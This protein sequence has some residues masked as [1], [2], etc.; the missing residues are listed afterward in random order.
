MFIMGFDN[1]DIFEDGRVFSHKKQVYLKPQNNGSG[2]LKVNLYKN[3]KM[4]QAYLH[5]LVAET[6][7]PNPNNY[8][9][10]DHIDMNK[11]N[12]CITNLRWCSAKQNTDNTARKSRYG[13]SRSGAKHYSQ[14][15][16]DS[17]RFEF[18]NGK[19]VMEL[20][21]EFNIPRQSISRFIKEL[22]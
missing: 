22:Y 12:N 11:T 21:R 15:V 3:G 14:E 9:Y 13:V 20:N 4:H 8:K 18:K 10:I 16:I 7:I 17:I 19:K 5:R 6:F 2:Y 1:Y